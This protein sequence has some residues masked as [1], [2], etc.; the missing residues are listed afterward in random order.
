[1]TQ[2]I[3]VRKPWLVALPLVVGLPAVAFFMI[4]NRKNVLQTNQITQLPDD[5]PRAMHILELSGVIE[6]Y[7]TNDDMIMNMRE[8]A[9]MLVTH[10]S[11]ND[12]VLV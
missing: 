9:A 12:K 8:G 1:M 10:I 2:P 7:S 11:Q 6:I 4:Q 3:P 5:L